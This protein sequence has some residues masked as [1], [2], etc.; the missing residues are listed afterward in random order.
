MFYDRANDGLSNLLK[1]YD[2]IS[3]NN[4]EQSKLNLARAI[5]NVK[6]NV[7][8]NMN[9]TRFIDKNVKHLF[10]TNSL[11]LIKTHVLS[12]KSKEFSAKLVLRYIGLYR[13]IYFLIPDTVLLQSLHNV[14]DIRK[15]H[16]V[17][18]KRY[19]NRY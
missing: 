2:F 11:V 14:H 10:K 19:R 18:L 1:L 17:D 13:I 7:Q 4:V 9:R 5:Q 8:R 15:I 16:I 3:H 12:N 6:K